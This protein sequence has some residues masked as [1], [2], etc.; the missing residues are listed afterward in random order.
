MWYEKRIE[1]SVIRSILGVCFECLEH[2]VKAFKDNDL[3][4]CIFTI[5]QQAIKLYGGDLVSLVSGG[6]QEKQDNQN[7]NVMYKIVS[8]V[9]TGEEL[10]I[11]MAE[12]VKS[13]VDK[14]NY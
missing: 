8:L 6:G 13:I 10:A 9:F 7:S 1:E 3:K 4:D 2:Q 5:V 14:G 12:L 11:N